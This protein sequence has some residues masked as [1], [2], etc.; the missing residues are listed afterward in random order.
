MEPGFWGSRSHYFSRG[1]LLEFPPKAFGK[2]FS[3]GSGFA[4]LDEGGAKNL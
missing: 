1:G 2:A 4:G 3:G